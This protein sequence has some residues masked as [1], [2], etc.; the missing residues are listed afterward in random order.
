MLA[1]VGHFVPA[2]LEGLQGGLDILWL[3]G[4][5]FLFVIARQTR[6]GCEV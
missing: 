2:F 3:L 1:L 4:V 5:G 6:Q